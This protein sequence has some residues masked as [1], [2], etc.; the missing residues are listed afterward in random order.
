MDYLSTLFEDYISE[1]TI[2]FY[3]IFFLRIKL[4]LY[5]II[6]V[7]IVMSSIP[8][9]AVSFAQK[10]EVAELIA[11]VNKSYEVKDYSVQYNRMW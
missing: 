4:S 2:K 11:I 9:P 5:F 6:L 7:H 8:P 1:N 3:V 10:P